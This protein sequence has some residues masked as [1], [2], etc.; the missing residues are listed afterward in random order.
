[1]RNHVPYLPSEVVIEDGRPRPRVDTRFFLDH[2]GIPQ[3]RAL[4]AREDRPWALGGIEEGEEW[5]A[6][7]FSDQTPQEI[8]DERLAEL[9]TGADAIWLQAYEGMTLDQNHVWHTYAA[10]EI[11]FVLDLAGLPPGAAVLDVGCGDGRH[12]AAIAQ[13]GFAA[14]GVDISPRLIARAKNQSK[15]AGA[16]FEVADGREDLPPGPFELVLSLYDVIGS[17][18]N[19]E[20]DRLLL[21]NI[22]AALA[23]GG[24]LVATVMND[25]ATA[26]RLPSEHQPETN[27]EFIAA[28]EN[29][30]PST[31]MEQTGAV[32]N[33]AY[34]LVFNGTYYRK[35]QFQEAGWTL[36]AELVVR[37]RRFTASALRSL[38]TGAGFKVLE[39]RP[40]QSGQWGRSPALAER[41]ERAKELLL[42]ARRPG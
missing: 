11:E 20:D 25:G 34:L 27:G 31:T 24:L 19:P 29:L 40:V 18:A 15:L 36:P 21:A 9:L 7:T 26:S 16:S 32:F 28:L 3:L 41:D 13:L 39:I 2:E 22:G 6:C 4:A 10:Q 12:V 1:M 38:A 23:P 30:P 17:S 37:D 35:E 5:L 8:D 14:T 33:P 42:I